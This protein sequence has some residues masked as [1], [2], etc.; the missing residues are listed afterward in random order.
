V[1]EE[2][3]SLSWVSFRSAPPVRAGVAAP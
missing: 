3:P 1:I 2:W